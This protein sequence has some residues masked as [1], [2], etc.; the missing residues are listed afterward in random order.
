MCDVAKKNF[1][2]NWKVFAPDPELRQ[3][4]EKLSAEKFSQTD[5]NQKR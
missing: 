2:V 5:Y 1:G 4:A 3:H